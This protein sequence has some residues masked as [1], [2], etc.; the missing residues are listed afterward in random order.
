MASNL[1]QWA[2]RQAIP[3]ASTL[4]ISLETQTTAAGATLQEIT[5]Y[6]RKFVSHKALHRKNARK[7][8]SW[9]RH[10]GLYLREVK[11]DPNHRFHHKDW[12]ACVPC[13]RKGMLT[14]FGA[15]TTTNAST[16]LKGVH[17]LYPTEATGGDDADDA[18]HDPEGGSGLHDEEWDEYRM[19]PTNVK[20]VWFAG[21][22]AG[23]SKHPLSSSRK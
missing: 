3:G 17:S 16:H 13:D 2:A 14:L 8:K 22:H 18:E 12:W 4:P 10:H 23:T 21:C 11:D 20:E 1:Q 9:I 15:D 7:R 6:G 5:R 19:E